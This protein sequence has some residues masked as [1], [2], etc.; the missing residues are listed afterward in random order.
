MLGAGMSD[1]ARGEAATGLNPLSHHLQM[2]HS[3]TQTSMIV[4][5]RQAGANLKSKTN[6][7]G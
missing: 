1:R 5:I 4:S 6:E 2:L 3:R 7:R